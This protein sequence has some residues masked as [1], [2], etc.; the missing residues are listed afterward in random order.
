MSLGEHSLSISKYT[1]VEVIGQGGTSIVKLAKDETGA[2]VELKELNAPDPAQ[3][4]QYSDR[5]TREAA[6]AISYDHPCIVKTIG[7][8]VDARTLVLE[9]LPLGRIDTCLDKLDPTEKV[10][11]IVRMLLAVD[12][13]HGKGQTH[14]DLK[15]ANALVDSSRRVKL[16]DLGVQGPSA[17]RALGQE[18]G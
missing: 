12:Y 17:I 5:L 14:G 4:A 13:V 8:D 9:Y 18:W 7:F 11:A 15:P 10:I 1:E 16:C 6:I 2:N 3:A